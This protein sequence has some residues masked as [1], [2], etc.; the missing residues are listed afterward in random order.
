MN[1]F[2]TAD[3][4]DENEDIQIA[5]PIFKSYGERENFYGK[6]RTVSVQDDNSFVKKLVNEK[7]NGEVMVIDGKGS[8]KCALL[9][10]NLARSACQNGWA[11]FIINGCIRDSA[12][13]NKIDIGIK[14]IDTMPI[15]SEKRN[16]GEYGENLKF[17]NV[18]FEEGDYLYSDADGIIISKKPI[19]HNKESKKTNTSLP[20]NLITCVKRMD[21]E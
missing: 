7:V 3:L 13:I 12:I 20:Y 2:N 8:F 6:I 19:L 18:V 1:I 11:G 9:G 5:H 21:N 10:D 14:A 4:C 16:I 17:A 15:K